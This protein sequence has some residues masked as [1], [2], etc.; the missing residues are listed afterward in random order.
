MEIMTDR[1]SVAA[2]G[3][4]ANVVA[5]KAHEFVTRPSVVRV[6]GTASAV[7]LNMTVTVGN[8][9]F[10]QDQELNAQNRMP[11]YPDDFIVDAAG[12]PGDRIL[13]SLR[14]TTGGALNG[15]TKVEITPV[16]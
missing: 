15:F 16:R 7:G 13:V 14:N 2:N 11:I 3:T 6:Y 4:E 10:V 12:M 5:A 9:I 8:R 1:R